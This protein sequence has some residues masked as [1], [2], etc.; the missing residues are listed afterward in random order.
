MTDDSSASWF[1]CNWANSKN[2]GD[3][4]GTQV[5]SGMEGTQVKS[6]MEGTQVKSDMEGTQRAWVVNCSDTGVLSWLP[7]G[8]GC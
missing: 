3:M 4:E 8:S 7:V 2:L 6:D 1:A 5:K